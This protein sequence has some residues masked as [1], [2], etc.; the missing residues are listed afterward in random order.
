LGSC[1]TALPKVPRP[2]ELEH[3][4]NGHCRFVAVLKSYDFDASVTD[5]TQTSLLIEP[6]L[7][8]RVQQVKPA[9]RGKVAPEFHLTER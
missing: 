8:E 5:L 6:E 4:K 7:A 9:G 2:I 1:I 3:K